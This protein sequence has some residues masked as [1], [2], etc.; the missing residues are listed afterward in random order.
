[1]PLPNPDEDVPIFKNL[2]FLGQCY[3]L[4]RINPLDPSDKHRNGGGAYP[5]H[6]IPIDESLPLV[7]APGQGVRIPQGTAYEPES[8]AQ[9]IARSTTWFTSEDLRRTFERTVSTGLS[10]P[11]IFTFSAS[12]T[13]REFEKNT[14]STEN[15]ET[16]VQSFFEVCVLRF[17]EGYKQT[18]KASD[19]LIQ[20]LK[21]LTSE[22]ACKPF[23]EKYGTHYAYEIILGGSMYQRSRMSRKT[24]ESLKKRGVDV[25][26]GAEITFKKI[27]VGGS[28]G[29]A[30]ESSQALLKDK[31]VTFDELRWCGGTPN[32]DWS[33]WVDSVREDPKP[34]Q[35]GLKPLHELL[36]LKTVQ[37]AVKTSTNNDNYKVIQGHLTKAIDDYLK[38]TGSR[39]VDAASMSEKRFYIRDRWQASMAD[40]H[41][42]WHLSF[43]NGVPGLKGPS[44]FTNLVPWELVPVSG[45]ANEFHLTSRW[46]PSGGG[47]YAWANAVV[48]LDSNGALKMSKPGE[49]ASFVPWKLVPVPGILG[50]FYLVSRFKPASGT[51][52]LDYGLATNDTTGLRLVPPSDLESR[53]PWR[54]IR[55]NDT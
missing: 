17:A 33:D 12:H 49:A 13:V 54:F 51:A 32:E 50:E 11:F 27:S 23:I 22:E 21:T 8:R 41:T 55:V 2:E 42:D 10:I 19:A 20:D 38:K 53:V 9:Q 26:L 30:E 3:D 25:S 35:L 44:D 24:Y 37:E 15:V 47:S 45:T 48:G 43:S 18:A 52:Y 46:L 14:Q 16:F 36:D 5:H 31:E 39:E 6:A 40:P 28:Y 29:S 34:I 7:L 1:M 4:T